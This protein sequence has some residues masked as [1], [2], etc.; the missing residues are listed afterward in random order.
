VIVASS[1]RHG[2]L[3]TPP[4]GGGCVGNVNDI[5]FP[6]VPG[7]WTTVISDY[8]CSAFGAGGWSTNGGTLQAITSDAC[9]PK[10]PQKNWQYTFDQGDTGLCGSGPALQ[11][12]SGLNIQKLYAGCYVKF[13]N[14]FDFFGNNINFPNNGEVHLHAV[15]TSGGG[16]IV[17]DIYS[18]HV[19]VVN[20]DDPGGTTNYDSST[21]TYSI[22]VYHLLETIYD[23]V[24]ATVTVY[25]DGVQVLS[26][27]TSFN[28]DHITEFHWS[29]TWGGCTLGQGVAPAFTCYTWCNHIHLVSP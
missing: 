4:A 23:M 22:G 19:E 6:N 24:G 1:S 28:S 11:Y 27:S 18:D 10:A 21:G 14:P 5:G 20:E 8:D 25:V 9:A 15:L 2:G 13:S 12:I 17:Q 7:T 26:A 3:K 16:S 29:N